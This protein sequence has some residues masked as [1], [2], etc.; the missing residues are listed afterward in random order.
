MQLHSEI[1]GE[2]GHRAQFPPLAR[3]GD[4]G[5]SSRAAV[6]RSRLA[7]ASHQHPPEL[8]HRLNRAARSAQFPLALEMLCGCC[9]PGYYRVD[10]L[11]VMRLLREM[12]ACDAQAAR[13]T[14]A[15]RR[16]EKVKEDVIGRG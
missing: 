2:R 11:P 1:S 15:V 16:W 12:A 10:E 13:S 14:V 4:D 6:P 7:N 3:T 8:P 9:S 5:A